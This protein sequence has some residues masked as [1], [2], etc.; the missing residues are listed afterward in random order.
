MA[1]D[2]FPGKRL[3]ACLDHVNKFSVFF[4]LYNP[5]VLSVPRHG[6]QGI[7]GVLKA[8]SESE[9]LN[10]CRL[11]DLLLSYPSRGSFMSRSHC[12]KVKYLEI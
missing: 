12:S 2:N 3:K 6:Y 1:H 10:L 5:K 7:G 4:Y 9:A 11:V 8:T